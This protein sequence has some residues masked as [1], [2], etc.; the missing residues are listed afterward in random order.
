MKNNFLLLTEDEALQD[1]V[2]ALN[3]AFDGFVD[4][5]CKLVFEVIVIGEEEMRTLN[6][7]TRGIDKVTDVLS[8]PA[9][10]G[11]KGKRIQ[12]KNFPL[13]VDEEGN[14][15]VGSIAICLERA[16]EQAKEYGHSYERELH[17]LVVHGVMHC[18]GYDHMTDE[19]KVEMR[20]KEEFILE[21]LG[22]TR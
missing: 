5:D 20:E 16:K 4:S 21:K 10:D 13:D 6:R 15:I 3:G 7:E 22:V 8:Y 1:L 18:L 9:L 11:I 12:K 14:L 17:Y 19:E 2:F